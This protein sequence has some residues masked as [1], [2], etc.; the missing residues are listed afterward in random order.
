MMISPMPTSQKKRHIRNETMKAVRIHAYGGPEVLRYENAMRPIPGAGEVLVRVFAAAVNPVDWKIREGYLKSMVPHSFPLTLGWDFSGVVESIGAGVIYWKKGDDV[1]TRPDLS[2][3]GAYADYIVVKALDLASK[4][5]SIDHIRAAAVPLAGLTAWQS[6]FDAGGLIGGQKVLVHAAAGGVGCFA[7]QLA[8]WAGAYVV[9][10]ASSRHRDFV[11]ALGADEVIDY[12]TQRFE[13]FVHNVDLVLDTIGGD[14][15]L[16]S[17]HTLKKGG[18]LVS[19]VHPPSQQDA[20]AHAARGLVMGVQTK[21]SQLEELA[22]LIESGKLKVFVETV[23]P[24]S[25]A[26]KAQDLIRIG[27]V[28]GKIVL[29]V[30]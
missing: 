17:W 9:G 16:R 8:K 28:R 10:T 23:F 27:H 22:K 24:L 21:P 4:P 13:D 5:K 2:G 18:V 11:K 7:V 29:K 6:L 12:Q 14:T 3:N 25:D 20:A 1:Y 15:Q 19:T 26:R 30:V